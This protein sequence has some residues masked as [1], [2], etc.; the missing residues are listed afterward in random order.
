MFGGL[1]FGRAGGLIDQ[2]DAVRD[3]QVLRSVPSGLVELQNDDAI[4][5]GAGLARQSFEQLGKERLV[6]TVRQIP[7]DCALGLKFI[8]FVS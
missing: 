2:A 3:G 7:D 5:A 4:A 6:Q 8:N 1:Q